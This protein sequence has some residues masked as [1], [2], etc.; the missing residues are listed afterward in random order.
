MP[1]FITAVGARSR[2]A[3]GV[4][5]AVAGNHWMVWVAVGVW[6]KVAEGLGVGCSADGG[7]GR[8]PAVNNN[9]MRAS[10]LTPLA[11]LPLVHSWKGGKRGILQNHGLITFRAD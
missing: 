9:K 10:D 7:S 6:V 4:I 3:K 5:V 1:G 2:V 11:P 8:H